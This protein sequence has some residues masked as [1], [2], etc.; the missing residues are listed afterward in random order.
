M[1]K[2]RITAEL[3]RLQMAIDRFNDLNDR[4]DRRLGEVELRLAQL[5]RL[6]QVWVDKYAAGLIVN[7]NW[8]TL[9]RWRA[10]EDKG[11]MAGVHWQNDGGKIVYHA[12]MLSH[13]YANRATPNRHLEAIVN[14]RSPAKRRGRPP[15]Q[16]CLASQL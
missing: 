14:S 12:E 16:K 8:K 7:R 2:L 3:T 5:D 13:W 1:G 4:M 15:N 9:E 10:D 6:S 11:L